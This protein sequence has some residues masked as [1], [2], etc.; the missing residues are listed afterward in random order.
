MPAYTVTESNRLL[1]ASYG[2]ATYLA[3]TTPIKQRL[4]TANGNAA[5]AGTEVTGGSYTS[6][7]LPMGSASA[8]ANA[9][10]GAMAYTGMPASTVV[11]VEEWDSAGSPR[12]I[13]FGAL[14]ASRTLS[15]GDTLNFATSAVQ[16]G[17]T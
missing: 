14:T 7:T 13:S 3:P 2:V 17:L 16:G 15:A 4:M 9:N 8:Q 1:D 6:Q 10:T 11:G 5:S 12:R